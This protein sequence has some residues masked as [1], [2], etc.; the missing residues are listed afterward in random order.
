MTTTQIVILA[1]VA[2]GLLCVGL[3]GWGLCMAAKLGEDDPEQ[4]Y[5]D[6]D[7]ETTPS[8]HL[9]KNAGAKAFHAE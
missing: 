1:I 4:P 9:W 3:V 8:R 2:I 7:G 5:A 6:A